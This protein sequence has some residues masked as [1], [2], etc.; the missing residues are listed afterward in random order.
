MPDALGIGAR[1]QGL[2]GGSVARVDDGTAA[3]TNPAGLALPTQ[4][5]FIVGGFGARP[6]VA[7][8]PL[9]AWDTNQDGVV[10][11]RD[12]GLNWQPTPPA[13]GAIDLSLA[14]PL[15]PWLGAGITL[16]VPTSSLIRFA[17]FDPQLPSYIRWNNRTQRTHLAIG[18][19]AE[20]RDGLRLGASIDLLAQGLA[21]ARLTVDA[22]ASGDDGSTNAVLDV[23]DID[24]RVI[25]TWA[26]VV[27][28]QLDLGSLHPALAPITLGARYHAQVGLP[29]DVDL[30]LQAN[31]D[32]ED[33]GS[34]EPYVA[35]LV[36]SAELA[37]FDHYVPHQIDGGAS[38]QLG[39]HVAVHGDVRWMDWRRLVLNVAQVERAELLVPFLGTV[40]DIRDGN[41]YSATARSTF[42]ARVGAEG[43]LPLPTPSGF[44]EL[45]LALRL[46]GLLDPTPLVDQ[47]AASSMLDSDHRVLTSGVGVLALPTHPAVGPLA[48]DVAL[49]WHQ[50]APAVL[51]RA[52]DPY[53]PGAPLSP[54]GLPVGGR[55]VAIGAALRFDARPAGGGP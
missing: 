43:S 25:P 55:F 44:D 15:Y 36:A 50:L 18:L 13:I 5:R 12:P 16:T 23:Q 53:Q 33:F 35:A 1:W 27:G 34:S 51:D 9:L 17:T 26:P 3:L 52:V 32:A 8:L 11:E 42:G 46:G 14:G 22:V 49:Q 45:G 31:A 41:P 47:T 7:Q 40:D 4:R 54:G 24:L 6:Q 48:L 37:L 28:A 30:D 2:G 38:V 10:D 19:A 20:P 29:L 39:R 21:S